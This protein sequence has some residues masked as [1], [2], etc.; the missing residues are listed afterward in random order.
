M[1]KNKETLLKELAAI[2]E[3]L[4]LEFVQADHSERTNADLEAECDKLEAAAERVIEAQ[5]K[6]KELES[7]QGPEAPAEI[8]Q[9]I[10]LRNR[11][12][13]HAEMVYRQTKDVINGQVLTKPSLKI[14]FEEIAA[15]SGTY[16]WNSDTMYR[17]P[18]HI[19]EKHG[20]R[21]GVLQ[22]IKKW[23]ETMAIKSPGLYEIIDSSRYELLI[24]HP[25]LKEQAEAV[26][27]MAMKNSRDSRYQ[28]LIEEIEKLSAEAGKP[29]VT[30]HVVP[31]PV[32]VG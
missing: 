19:E 11:S 26:I 7:K 6:L 10:I 32:S 2:Y 21:Q 3:L 30:S 22:L 28:K 8:K 20:G 18:A 14:E 13:S 27:N 17:V 29:I 1:A 12:S 4:G 16:C 25:Y 5:E 24:K 15:K 9:L 31:G 23:A